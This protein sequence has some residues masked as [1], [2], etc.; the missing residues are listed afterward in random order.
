MRIH[1]TLLLS[2][3][4]LPAL[5][6][7]AHAQW[8]LTPPADTTPVIAASGVGEVLAAP[9]RAVIHVAVAGRD[10]ARRAATAA[11]TAARNRAIAALADAG[12]RAENV[13]L[14]AAGMGADVPLGA[15]P[16]PSREP[17]IAT[18]F[19]LRVVVD[20]VSRLDAALGALSRAGVDAIQCVRFEV[21]DEAAL[22][23]A[24]DRAVAQARVQAEARAAAA[25]VRLGEL[26]ALATMPWGHDSSDTRLFYPGILERGAAL[27]PSDVAVRV[28]VQA[29][30]RIAAP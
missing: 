21:G 23:R 22:R 14:T 1:H 5:R 11:A 7:P 12:F 10:T 29:S 20:P 18:R 25:G 30:W 3:M 28:M 4:L 24:T 13:T 8:F 19:G 6:E 15:A 27:L 2:L 16:S 9:R 17:G 26:R